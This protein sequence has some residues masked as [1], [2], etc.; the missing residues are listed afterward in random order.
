MAPLPSRR[1]LL[2]AL[3]A[4]ALTRASFAARPLAVS[5][6]IDLEGALLG[7]MM[8]LALEAA[9]VPAENRLRIGPTSILRAA[10]LSGAIDLCPDY[11]GNAAV[12]FH[13]EGNPV[14]REASA[15]YARAAKLDHEQNRIVWLAPA[16]ADNSWVIAV[17]EQLEREQN[18]HT[19]EDFARFVR[20]GNKVKLAASAEFIESPA[21]LPAFEEAYG[22]RLSARQLLVLSGGETPATMKAAADGISGVNAAMA[23][24]S[25]G[26]LKSLGLHALEDICHVEPV[27]APAPVIREAALASYPQISAILAP[28]FAK[29]DLATLRGLNEKVAVE[30]F[31]PGSVAKEFFRAQGLLR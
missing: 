2:A 16:P 21:G 19:M 29:L 27:Y 12:F 8:L 7:E 26:G 23:Y 4:Q 6:K 25:D 3:A 18:L 24:A 10:L 14:W 1:Q 30:G 11:T 13:E 15:G 31:H 9:G 5:S 28:V 17:P 22:F 20:E